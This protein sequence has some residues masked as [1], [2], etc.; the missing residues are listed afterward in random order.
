MGDG[1]LDTEEKREFAHRAVSAVC[2]IAA[3]SAFHSS[4]A[5]SGAFFVHGLSLYVFAYEAVR[6]NSQNGVSAAANFIAGLS[7]TLSF[8]SNPI[9]PAVHTYNAVRSMVGKMED[10]VARYRGEINSQLYP[11]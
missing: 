10:D 6:P 8:F 5:L 7:T 11:N 3:F 1:F 2:A 9:A 4:E